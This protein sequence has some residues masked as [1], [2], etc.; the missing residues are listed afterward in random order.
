M[1]KFRI[2]WTNF[3][4]E[5]EISKSLL[6]FLSVSEVYPTAAESH[7]WL[8]Q[9]TTCL[10]VPAEI[11]QVI[12]GITIMVLFCDGY[13]SQIET[14]EHKICL[15]IH[16][17]LTNSTREYLRDC[18]SLYKPPHTVWSLQDPT[19]LQ[20]LNSDFNFSANCLG[21]AAPKAWITIPQ[22]REIKSAPLFK[23]CSFRNLP[24]CVLHMPFYRKF[25]IE[26]K[27]F[28]KNETVFLDKN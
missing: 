17:I 3:D 11:P 21:S 20:I 5:T 24:F 12:W 6:I 14:H 27:N 15:H 19:R 1:L 25:Q 18:I 16:E 4:R 10:Y 7:C 28:K 26:G 22:N 9:P 13:D 23:Q 2:Y 8:H